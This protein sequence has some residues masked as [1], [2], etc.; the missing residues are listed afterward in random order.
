MVGTATTTTLEATAE[1][2]EPRF[3]PRTDAGNGE[4]FAHLYRDRTRFD[5]KRHHWLIWDGFRQIFPSATSEI[6]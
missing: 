1:A 3:F 6:S 2:D 4:L 5:H